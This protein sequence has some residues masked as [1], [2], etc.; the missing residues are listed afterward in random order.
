MD[1]NTKGTVSR[2]SYEIKDKRNFVLQVDELIT[3]GLFSC[4]KACLNLGIPLLYYSRWKKL[5]KKVDAL[6]SGTEFV[7]YNTKGTSRK[8]HPVQ[9]SV[10]AQ[11]K[12]QLQ[13]F[14][15]KL[16]KQGVQVTNRMVMQEATCLLPDF[17]D[18][19]RRAQELAVHRFT[20]SIGLAYSCATHTAQKHFMETE[21]DAKDFIAVMK[22]KLEG[23]NLDNILNMDQTLIPLSESP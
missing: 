14:T 11:V 10:L 12:E 8:I 21:A 17:K 7:P 2:K 15:F 6:N 1:A 22:S 5:L 13:A 20:Q 9:E 3:T 18:K 16:R 23:R 19:T 4:H